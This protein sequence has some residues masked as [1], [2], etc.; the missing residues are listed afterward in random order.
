MA[1]AKYKITL[2]NEFEARNDDWTYADFENRLGEL[3]KGT[4]YHDAKSTI[5]D[6]HKEGKWP[7]TVKRYLI[8][9]R[10]TM[11]SWVD[12]AHNILG[13]LPEAQREE[14]IKEA[15]QAE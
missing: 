10:K 12:I 6:A 11:G 2:L 3:R 1:L 13:S 14:W 7:K 15:N 5:S 4:S 8:S 9:N